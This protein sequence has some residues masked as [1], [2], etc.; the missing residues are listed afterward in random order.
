MIPLPYKGIFDGR[1]EAQGCSTMEILQLFPGDQAAGT[2]MSLF[3]VWLAL[4]CSTQDVWTE[5]QP[6]WLLSL[7]YYSCIKQ[8]PRSLIVAIEYHLTPP[9]K[10]LAS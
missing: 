10:M 3:V 5:R 2:A 8:Y 9:M 4:A 7:L 6:S 1:Q